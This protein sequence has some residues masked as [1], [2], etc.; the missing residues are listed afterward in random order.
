MLALPD[1]LQSCEPRQIAGC[2]ASPAR[3]LAVGQAPLDRWQMGSV[4]TELG[5]VHGARQIT[6]H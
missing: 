1:R 2:W 5:G 3:S 6:G 4:S